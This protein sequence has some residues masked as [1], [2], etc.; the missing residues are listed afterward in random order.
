MN[1]DGDRDSDDTD[2][3]R[4]LLYTRIKSLIFEKEKHGDVDSCSICWNDFHV[5]EQVKILPKWAHIFHED[6]IEKW[7]LKAKHSN[8]KCP[9]WRVNIKE[10][11]DIEE[12]KKREDEE[13]TNIN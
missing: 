6:W 13:D 12:A 10:E 4:V 8:I 1:I 3:N 11:L 7:I 9:V 5:K 2:E